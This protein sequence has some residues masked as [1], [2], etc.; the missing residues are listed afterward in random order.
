[1]KNVKSI[2][3]V[4]EL[5]QLLES[6]DENTQL[7]AFNVDSKGTTWYSDLV[8]CETHPIGDRDSEDTLAL[9]FGS[10]DSIKNIQL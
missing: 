10:N 5:K 9:S 7:S 3:N 2:N 8:I 1:M 4:R 6:V